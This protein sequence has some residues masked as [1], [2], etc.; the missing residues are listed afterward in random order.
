[1]AVRIAAIAERLRTSLFFEPLGFVVV[2][3]AL[4]FAGL[5]IDGEVLEADP[6]LPFGLTSTVQSARA[7]LSTVAGATIT[8]AGIAF[9]ISLLL[10]QQTSSQYSPRVV[11]GL[12]RDPFNKRVMG[13]AVGT[14]TYCLVV[15]RSVRS[16][17]EDGG[18]P[19]VPHLSVA[20]AVVLGVVSILA[21]VAF[22][23]HSAHTMEVS[24]ILEEVSQQAR[25]QIRRLWPDSD[26]SLDGDGGAGGD[27]G[28]APGPAGPPGVGGTLDIAFEASGWIQQIDHAQLARAADA[29]GVVQL[30]TSVGRYA[31]PGTSF[32][33]VSPAPDDP[34]GA[35]VRARRSV[36]T[37]PTRTL[38]Q[39]VSYGL[40][41][42]AD[43]AIKALS[44]AVNDPT[45]AQDALFHLGG[46]LRELLV[47]RPP[48]AR[49]PMPDGRVVELTEEPTP[50]GFVELAF[51]EIRLAA[52]GMPA[53]CTY[54]LE[55][56]H[57]VERS[58]PEHA[59][60]D[61][62]AALRNQARLV[63]AGADNADLLPEDRARIRMA[64]DERFGRPA[65]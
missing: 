12:F 6:D 50:A 39:D 27:G 62:L 31:V 63:R 20:L 18:D 19:V 30:R 48:P 25:H 49:R 2:A 15:L 16:P 58:L 3:I 61:A 43:V 41:Q 57:L 44:P 38:Q 40:R 56:L 7:V 17:L 64:H 60:A 26:G 23:S 1:M 34:E 29:G 13:T 35:A 5:W 46:V 9:S 24:R 21:I 42:L 4:A 10:I 28:H 47:R 59:D 22:I 45:T 33:E 36:V 14:F 54:L 37:G 53:V 52:E 11:H 55:V 51:D 65:G 32:C 8:V